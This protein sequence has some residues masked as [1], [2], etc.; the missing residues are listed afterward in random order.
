MLTGEDWGRERKSPDTG[1]G[2]EPGPRRLR[3]PLL[4]RNLF[5][6]TRTILDSP[7]K[8]PRPERSIMIMI[9]G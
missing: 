1:L 8:H 2:A 3:L 5:A 4:A 9:R 6:S 7:N